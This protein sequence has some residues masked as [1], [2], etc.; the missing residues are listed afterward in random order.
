MEAPA[1]VRITSVLIVDDS[2]VQREHAVALCLQ[3]GVKTVHTAGNGSEAVELLAGLAVKPDLVLLDL[4]MPTLDGTQTLELMQQRGIDV[5]ILMVSARELS[6]LDSVSDLG[7][8]LGL[9]IV[10]ALQKPLSAQHL[11]N[12]LRTDIPARIPHVPRSPVRV[13]SEDL[14]AALLG[15]EIQVHYQ[16]KVQVRTAMIRG[17]EA[18]ARWRHPVH[19]FVAP[20]EFIPLAEAGGLIH[21]LTMHVYQKVMQQAS[22]W[23]AHGI[24]LSIAVNL[25]PHLLDDPDLPARMVGLQ[26]SFDI[27]TNKLTFEITESSLVSGQSVPLA[28][29]TRLRLKGF[30]LSIDDY[31]TG[32]S[33]MQ[34]LTR[35]PFTELKIDR[36]F[37]S[38]AHD[39]N[40]RLVILRS[41]I[42]MA[43]KLGVTA[44]AE[45]VETDA[46]WRM[47]QELSCDVA[48]GFFIAKP[49]PGEAI[50]E[51]LKAYGPRMQGLRAGVDRDPSA[52]QA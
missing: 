30:G 5:P 18:L 4:E 31:G 24:H 17:V 43:G 44:V 12:M 46:E 52:I 38:H 14:R 47:L 37:I 34:Q 13:T 26:Q 16:P 28:I 20:S 11:V 9:R 50:M 32:F 1:R 19:G 42:E 23:M 36:S 45:G 51:W 8:V 22:I 27:P 48:Q 41:A 7:R 25:S 49:M 39:R 6:L 29:L 33:S 2:I 3:L 10:G 21:E 35:I 15:D 40:S